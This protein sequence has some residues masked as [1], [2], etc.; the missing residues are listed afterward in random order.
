[1]FF[2]NYYLKRPAAGSEST[3]PVVLPTALLLKEH[4]YPAITKKLSTKY[5]T[6]P[7]IYLLT[8]MFQ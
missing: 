5:L 7:M 1:M 2:L 8:M 4:V 6:E 3:E